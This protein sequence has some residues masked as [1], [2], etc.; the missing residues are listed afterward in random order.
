MNA[1]GDYV[2]TT[3]T[4]AD[5]PDSYYEENG[6]GVLPMSF[7]I[8]DRTY[9]NQE[10]TM[11]AREFYR[12]LRGGQ[13]AQTSQATP[14]EITSFFT[15]Y[16]QAGRDILHLSFSSALSG[17]YTNALLAAGELAEKYP[18]RRITVIDSRCASLGEGLFVYKAVE[19]KK[20]GKTMEEVARWAED[21]KLRISHLFT[22]DDLFHLYR[23]GR[24]TKA[25]AFVGSV[26]N[27]KP[28]LKVDNEGKLVQ[29]AKVRGRKHSIKS[30]VEDMEKSLG[31]DDKTIF[32]SHGDCP[33]D[34][35]YAVK[36]IREQMGLEPALIN[37]I[38]PTIG[39]HSGPGTLAIFF[40]VAER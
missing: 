22:V 12:L 3:D 24:V 11:D 18:D 23:G 16:L 14:V 36:L 5:L 25:T 6:I 20:T 7:T 17:T 29:Y 32:I 28:L 13:M 31:G 37:D 27:V 2:I 9:P 38:G 1:S 33:E 26:L 8:N 15:P 30:L 35:E 10:G 34:V 39:T 4:G 40:F 19:L 21:N